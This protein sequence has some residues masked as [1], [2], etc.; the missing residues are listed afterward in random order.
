MVP[1][2]RI[3]SAFQ[4]S[5][6]TVE[7][8]A[9]RKGCF[10]SLVVAG[11]GASCEGGTV[12]SA[13]MV[14]EVAISSSAA[15]RPIGLNGGALELRSAVNDSDVKLD[16]KWILD[17]RAI[18]VQKKIGIGGYAEVWKALWKERTVAFK[19]L[20]EDTTDDARVVEEFRREMA[21]FGWMGEKRL[22]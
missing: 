19:L 4:W 12:V 17:L 14:T 6:K 7:N 22:F 8:Q 3:L 16:P 13:D 10:E 9:V 5:E 21:V 20:Q 1:T 18:R 2:G 15:P 11:Q